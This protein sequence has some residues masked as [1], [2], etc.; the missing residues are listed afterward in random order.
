M[1]LASELKKGGLVRK[2]FLGASFC[3]AKGDEI[4]TFLG[5]PLAAGCYISHVCLG[6]LAELSGVKEGDMLYRV[7][8]L[9]IDPY[10]YVQGIF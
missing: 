7:N 9:S 1:L 5:N 10:G 6:G 2:P 3:T 4:A 8:G